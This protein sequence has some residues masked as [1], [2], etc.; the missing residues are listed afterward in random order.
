MALPLVLH[1]RATDFLGGP[2][3]QILG[4]IRAASRYRHAV[5]TF[6]ERGRA[7][8]LFEACMREGI[9]VRAVPSAGPWDIAAL[10]RLR[11]A[12]REMK[13]AILCTH[14]YKPSV[15]VVIG[16]MARRYPLVAFSRGDTGESPRVSFYEA[17]ERK[18]IGFAERIICVSEAQKKRL[19]KY[20]IDERRCRVVHNAVWEPE[21][22]CNDPS[23]AASVRAQL[24]I[25][26]G[27][28]LVVSAGRLSPEKGHAYLIESVAQLVKDKIDAVFAFCGDG[29]CRDGLVALAER[30]GVADICR[31]P[32]FRHDLKDIFHAMDLLVLPSLTE[33]LPNVVLEAFACGKPVVATSVGGVPEVV[34][35]GVNG[36]LV[37]PRRPD[38]L[39]QAILHCLRNP[40]ESRSMGLRGREIVADEF[41]F[42]QQNR[43]LE[44][45]YDE[46][47]AEGASRSAARTKPGLF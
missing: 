4:H 36:I 6:W 18:A 2:E 16:G 47:I 3:K 12:I 14:G 43:R 25:P 44:A 31:F 19:L 30:K 22:R 26:E 40:E 45:I 28:K 27:G 34:R 29:V 10:S 24:E 20:G 46:V 7:G 37:P 35:D 1:I 33:G 9:P 39:A 5:I 32:G 41:T 38:L 11:A 8:A 15:M 17:I 21:Y 13:P 23:Y 42:E